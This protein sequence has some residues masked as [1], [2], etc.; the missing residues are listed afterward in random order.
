MRYPNRR[1]GNPT[2][3]QHYAISYG[4]VAELA[5]SLRRSERSVRDWLS[6]RA[7]VPWWVPEILRLRA[8]EH[9]HIVHQITGQ[10]LAARLG[11]AT[12]AGDVVDAGA[13]FRQAPEQIEPMTP[14]RAL[15]E[16]MKKARG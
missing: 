7:K 1:Y 13:R 3:M 4:T 12:P 9:A 8:L 11:I 14:A 16:A 10:Q 15:A 6:G 5:K 2:E